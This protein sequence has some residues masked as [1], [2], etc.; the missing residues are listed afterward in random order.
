MV[1]G[2]ARQVTKKG[3]AGPLRAKLQDRAAA[4]KRSSSK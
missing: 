4:A 1:F 3:R 2:R